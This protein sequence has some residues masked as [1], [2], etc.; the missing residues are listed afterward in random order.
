MHLV[1]SASLE[2]Y[3]SMASAPQEFQHFPTFVRIRH[4]RS[5]DQLTPG[6][7]EKKALPPSQTIT[8][9]KHS[10]QLRKRKS[11]GFA[12][13]CDRPPKRLARTNTFHLHTG[14]HHIRPRADR[15]DSRSTHNQ[16]PTPTNDN[17][18]TSITP[19]SQ[20]DLQNA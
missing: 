1:L 17:Q 3:K 6:A 8:T 16:Y 9:N 11:R 12:R 13:S 18:Q 10:H 5:L 19:N 20:F 7:K 14:T 4:I 2:E 15:I